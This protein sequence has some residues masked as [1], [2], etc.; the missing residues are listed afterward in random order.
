MW[1]AYCAL[2]FPFLVDARYDL[3]VLVS[4]E[5]VGEDREGEGERKGIE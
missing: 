5:R 1:S 4:R 3:R 2:F